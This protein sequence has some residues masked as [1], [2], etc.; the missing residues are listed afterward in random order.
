MN[1]DQTQGKLD[2][3]K[4]EAKRGLGKLTN[5]ETTEAEGN[6]DKIKGEAR[7]GVGDLKEKAADKVNDAFDNRR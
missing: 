7:E 5:D 3:L 4:G 1:D 6:K 2:K